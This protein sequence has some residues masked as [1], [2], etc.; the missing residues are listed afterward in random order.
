M[1]TPIKSTR[2]ARILCGLCLGIGLLLATCPASL[3][4]GDWRKLVPFANR[5]EADPKADYKLTEDHGPW[6][7]LAASF[8][9]PTADQQARDLVLELRKRY[10]MRAY[11]HRRTY[12]FTKP[13]VGLGISRTGGPKIM[14]H[15]QDNRFSEIAVLVGHFDNVDSKSLERALDRIKYLHPQSLDFSNR[16]YSSQRFSGLRQFYR[17][18]SR[19]EAQRTKGMMAKAFV[20]RNPLIPAEYFAP[21]GLDSLVVKMN[22][23]V[24]HSLLKNPAPY[25]VRVA[26]FRGTS[27]FKPE[28]AAKPLRIGNQPTKLELAAEKAHQMTVALRKRGVE[29]WEFHDRYESVVTIGSFKSWG[30]DLSNGAIEINPAMLSIIKTYGPQMKETS[31]GTGLKP[32]NERGIPFDMQP[33]PMRVP[34]GSIAADYARDLR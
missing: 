5:V 32:R 25:T 2:F 17:Q 16:D 12:D 6:L 27:S 4:A 13:V 28:D 22:K 31:R 10:Q 26:T 30:K 14:K 21:K 33:E 1:K 9:G 20:T 3:E 11:T 34:R 7:I 15:K 23:N 18:L 8:A 29:A 19:S 24:E